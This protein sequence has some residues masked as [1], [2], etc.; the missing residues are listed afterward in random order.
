MALPKLNHPSFLF[1]VPS[2]KQDLRFRPFLVEE[3]KLLLTAKESGE[4]ADMIHAISHV[5]NN[6]VEDKDFDISKHPIFDMEYLFLNIRSKSI[7]NIVDVTVQDDLT[8]EPIKL[9][10]NLDDVKVVG[11]EDVKKEFWFDSV[12]LGVRMLYP[13]PLVANNLKNLTTLSQ[14]T[15]QLIYDCIDQV[16]DEENV[17]PWAENTD[18]EKHTFLDSLKINDYNELKTFFE[19][20]PKVY[21]SITYKNSNDEEKK[22]EFITLEDFFTWD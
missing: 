22:I 11:L 14:I 13:T 17:Y 8:D 10:I 19:N 3:E 2:T 12:K 18:E 16:F 15:D 9:Q 6:C 4:R 21:H 7:N 20:L 1:R 5:I